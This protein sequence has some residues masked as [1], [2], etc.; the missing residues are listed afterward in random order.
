MHLP[1]CSTVYNRGLWP[2][3]CAHF[4]CSAMPM[5]ADWFASVAYQLGGEQA[6]HLLNLEFFVLVLALLYDEVARRAGPTYG[7][8]FVAL[9]AS[10]P[11]AFIENATLFVENPL[12]AFMFASFLILVRRWEHFGRLDLFALAVSNT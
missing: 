7:L 1:I 4:V 2:F 3:D 5:N 11:V 9:F 6:T 8:C 10:T 12:T